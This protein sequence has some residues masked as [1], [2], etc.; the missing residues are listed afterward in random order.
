MHRL[1]LAL[2]NLVHSVP[3][4]KSKDL[5]TEVILAL[6]D[7]DLITTEGLRHALDEISIKDELGIRDSIIAILG[8]TLYKHAT[9][10]KMDKVDAFLLKNEPIQAIKEY[11]NIYGTSLREAKDKVDERKAYLNRIKEESNAPKANKF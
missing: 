7:C 6:E 5:H 10:C 8:M 3:G 1:T 9:L 11:R 4:D 2:F